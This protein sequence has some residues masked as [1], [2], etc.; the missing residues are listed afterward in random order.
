MNQLQFSI[1]QFLVFS[2]IMLLVI[3]CKKEEITPNSPQNP[4]TPTSTTNPLYSGVTIS[5]SIGGVVNDEFGTPVANALVSVGSDQVYTNDLGYFRLDNVSVDQNRAFIKVEK[6]GYF[7]GA[8]SIKP[9]T[10]AISYVR[11]QLILKTLE[12][13]IDNSQGGTISVAGGPS[14]VFEAGDVSKE[15]GDPYNGSV[16]VFAKYLN[17]T[18]SNIG[19]IIPGDLDA[20][21]ENGQAVALVTYGMLA[22]ELVGS[23][24][25]ALNVASG[26]KVELTFPV[27][28]V[29]TSTAPASI[30][31]WFFDETLG[32]WQ[33]DGSASLQG[34][35]YVGEV[36]HFT[37][38]NC[39]DPYPAVKLKLHIH[40]GNSPMANATVR[41]ESPSGFHYGT[42]YTNSTGNINELIPSGIPLILK[43]LDDCGNV[44]YQQ[45]LGICTAD[46][47]LGDIELCNNSST[48]TA[49]LKDCNGV[50]ISSGLLSVQIGSNHVPLFTDANGNINSLIFTCITDSVQVSGFDLAQNLQST[51][52]WVQVS[53]NMNVGD[54]VI[55]DQIQ[56]Y[57]EYTLDGT[58][59][60][61]NDLGQNEVFVNT[62][63]LGP[64]PLTGHIGVMANDGPNMMSFWTENGGAGS[65]SNTVVP[66]ATNGVGFNV[67][68]IL[69]PPNVLTINYTDYGAVAGDYYEG[70]FQG[71]FDDDN[72]VNHTLSG[73][74]RAKRDN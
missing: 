42:A 64:V 25:E 22:V 26:E 47:N 12:G 30:P 73:I 54:I 55:C 44:I 71:T 62:S 29:Q 52:Q 21:D 69:G 46:T 35:S 2:A 28:S 14:I 45:N 16:S 33:E 27:Q 37:F 7:L 63:F 67:N 65:Y 70:T 59:F 32:N 53:A 60:V 50:P 4:S 6:G 66:G 43:I 74:F 9:S 49:V 10:S 17:P 58:Q 61:I 19:E 18:A 56:E 41:L 8:K 1:R 20:V 68:G 40:C 23:N 15:N 24:G 13:A 11:I 39:D 31:L 36:S 3:S 48:V 38:W 34:N 72:G 57:L 51:S 5:T